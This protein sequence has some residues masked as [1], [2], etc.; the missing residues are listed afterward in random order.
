MQVSIDSL[1][2]Q[3]PPRSILLV[4]I[5]H[6][7]AVPPLHA[8]SVFGAWFDKAA[9]LALTSLDDGFMV[10]DFDDALLNL[11]LPETGASGQRRKLSGVDP[12]AE[13]GWRYELDD[14][15][16]L[17]DLYP[18]LIQDLIGELYPAHSAWWAGGSQSMGPSLVICQGLPSQ[19]S[20]TALVSG[21]WVESGLRDLGVSFPA[22][23]RQSTQDGG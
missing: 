14:L 16:C 23:P 3:Q 20:F 11:E 19:R 9:A 6:R 22:A 5:P 2:L 7:L 17:P 21:N 4:A 8:F 13:T 1:P 12:V 10:T 15:D 18:F